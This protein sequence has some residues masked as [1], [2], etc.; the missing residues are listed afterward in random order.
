M[1]HNFQD[2][3]TQLNQK[4]INGK[5]YSEIRKE[6]LKLVKKYHLDKA[7]T[8]K[9]KLYEEYTIKIV[10]LYQN[11]MDK[12]IAAAEIDLA[13]QK[14]QAQN[15]PDKKHVAATNPAQDFTYIKLMEVARKEYTAYKKIGFGFLPDCEELKARIE[16]FLKHLGTAVKCY[17]TVIKE[18]QNPELVLA[19]RKQLEWVSRLYNATKYDY[20]S[21]FNGKVN[22]RENV[23]FKRSEL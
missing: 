16:Q 20:E 18:C 22:P 14:K 7:E 6:Y 8:S 2:D 19:A 5:P 10:N 9:K 12:K 13:N 4:L 17:K 15:Q 21:R 11:Y 23:V 1:I 3:F